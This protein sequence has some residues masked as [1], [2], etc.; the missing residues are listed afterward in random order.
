MHGMHARY[1]CVICMHAIHACV[2]YYACIVCKHNM[3]ACRARMPCVHSIHAY[4]ARIACMHSMQTRYV[5]KASH[6]SAR[7]ISRG[8]SGQVA[9]P[10]KARNTTNMPARHEHAS[11]MQTFC[12]NTQMAMHRLPN[13]RWGT[14]VP[15]LES[16]RRDLRDDGNQ[17]SVREKT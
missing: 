10:H 8:R 5:E 6:A 17:R 11:Y 2:A 3:Y 16:P 15:P 14:T 7:R 4:Y 13:V 1:A 12:M 9:P